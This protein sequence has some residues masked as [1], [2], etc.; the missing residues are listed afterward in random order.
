MRESTSKD[1]RDRRTQGRENERTGEHCVSAQSSS[2]PAVLPSRASPPPLFLGL[3]LA[4]GAS[5]RM[6]RPKALLPTMDGRPLAVWQADR[7]RAAGC[8]EVLI[9]IGSH[10][11]RGISHFLLG[12]VAERVVRLAGCPVLTVRSGQHQFVS[13]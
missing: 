13:S 1:G 7:L 12:S 2:R 11:R 6:G 8:A 5:S 10:G 4:A 3:V 9:V